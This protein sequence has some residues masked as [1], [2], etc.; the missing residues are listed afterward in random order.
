MGSEGGQD[1]VVFGGQESGADQG[2][3]QVLRAQ[4]VRDD[5]QQRR[6]Q[7]GD[8]GGRQGREPGLEVNPIEAGLDPVDPGVLTGGLD[9]GDIVVAALEWSSAQLAGRDRQYG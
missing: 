6:G 1:P 4:P 7:V 2:F 5:F 3:R 9:R 8:R